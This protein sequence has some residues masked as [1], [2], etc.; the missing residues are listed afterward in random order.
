[1]PLIYP[2]HMAVQ[3]LDWFSGFKSTPRGDAEAEFHRVHTELY[4]KD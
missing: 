2:D 3:I 1:M 4:E